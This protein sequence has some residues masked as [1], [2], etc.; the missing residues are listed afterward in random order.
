MERT[1]TK[2]K[3][4]ELS[5]QIK[6][7]LCLCWK[8]SFSLLKPYLKLLKMFSEQTFLAVFRRDKTVLGQNRKFLGG[9]K[10][11]IKQLSQ[12]LDV[13]EFFRVQTKLA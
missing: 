3:C 13:T 2:A 10:L 8:Q 12:C 11:N 5:K 1:V 6:T 4:A 9:A 7:F